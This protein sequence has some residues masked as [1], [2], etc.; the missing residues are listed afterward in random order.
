MPEL[1]LK[2]TTRNT[3]NFNNR[4]QTSYICF[5]L[6]F[7]HLSNIDDQKVYYILFFERKKFCSKKLQLQ[8]KFPT[9]V[10]S[11]SGFIWITNSSEHR[12]V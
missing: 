10:A 6:Q 1:W 9:A 11:C 2:V 7:K 5:H 8:A 4:G 3:G 12:R